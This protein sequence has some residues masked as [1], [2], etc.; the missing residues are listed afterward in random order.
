MVAD[1]ISQVDIEATVGIPLEVVAVAQTSVASADV[2]GATTSPSGGNGH[3]VSLPSQPRLFFMEQAVDP[4]RHDLTQSFETETFKPPYDYHPFL[5][6]IRQRLHHTS[7]IIPP[8]PTSSC[9]FP[10]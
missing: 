3:A 10:R 8:V 6:A 4:A 5:Q 1:V 2:G 7:R 9:Q